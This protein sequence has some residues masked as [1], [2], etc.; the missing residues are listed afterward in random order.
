M[1]FIDSCFSAP[2]NM[3]MSVSGIIGILTIVVL[4]VGLAGW[5]AYAYRNP[6]ST[7]GQMLIRVREKLFNRFFQSHAPSL[8]K[9]VTFIQ[10]PSSPYCTFSSL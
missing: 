1:I 7:S 6:H 4:V 5:G 2:S 3:N 10:L 8:R 9:R